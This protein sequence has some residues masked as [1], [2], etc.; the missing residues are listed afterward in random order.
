MKQVPQPRRRHA[1]DAIALCG[2][3]LVACSDGATEA[4]GDGATEVNSI[5]DLAGR[6]EA[7]RVEFTVIADPQQTAELIQQG[8][9][10]V[11]VIEND[12]SYRQEVMFPG[13]NDL[14]HDEGI[15]ELTGDSLV[16]DYPAGDGRVSFAYTLFG[17][18]LTL[19]ANIELERGDFGFTSDDFEVPARW[20]M[21]LRRS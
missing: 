18:V 8:G 4:S 15:V 5:T 7:T 3:V 13:D 17:E 10:L 20:E 12:G 16:F 1:L 14:E 6:W 2:T 21:N 9:S 19:V 11:L